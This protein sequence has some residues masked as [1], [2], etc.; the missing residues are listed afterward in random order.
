MDKIV[1]LCKWFVIVVVTV[2]VVRGMLVDN[3][4]LGKV[5]VRRSNIGG[6]V[7]R[8]LEPGWRFELVG[9]HKIIQL[10]STYQFLNFLDQNALEIRT[11]DNNIVTIDISVPY[12]ITPGSAWEIVTEGN[13]VE[14][15]QGGYRFQRLTRETTVGVLR[16][17]AGTSTLI[18]GFAR[19]ELTVTSNAGKPPWYCMILAG[20]LIPPKSRYGP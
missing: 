11:K 3:V 6:V 16:T 2:L 17:F 20:N 12:R 10:P 9:I 14:D 4:E 18:V 13:H 5:G 15:G 8:D 1:T 19:T 7:E